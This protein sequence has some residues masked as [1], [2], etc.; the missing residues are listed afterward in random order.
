MGNVLD[1]KEIYQIYHS[2]KKSQPLV[3]EISWSKLIIATQKCKDSLE[4]EFYIH[5]V[6]SLG[7]C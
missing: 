3:V 6:Q 7:R 2:N 4:R 5:F 1:M